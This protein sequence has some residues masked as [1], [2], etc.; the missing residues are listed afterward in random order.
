M[1][2]SVPDNSSSSAERSDDEVMESIRS[3]DETALGTLIER[4]GPGLF[5]YARGMLTS[6]D[7]AEDVVQE[8]FVRVW[9]HRE[10]WMPSGSAQAFL[11]RIA[12]NVVLTR[13]RHL[14]ARARAGAEIRDRMASPRTP[15]EE[16]AATEVLE[17]LTAAI[18][19]LP[20]RRREAYLLVRVHQLTLDEAA[21]VMDLTKR[22]V[23]NHVYMATSDLE[24]MLRP[25]L[26]GREE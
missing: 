9:E 12:R 24:R 16:V 3:G 25:H 15:L 23:S 4:H 7:D 8:T 5:R 10:R 13:A 20:D 11:Y 6:V 21:E 17:A 19:A 14:D 2:S 1:N 22:T 26:K 18:T